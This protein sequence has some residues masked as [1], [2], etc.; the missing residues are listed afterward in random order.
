MPADY[1]PMIFA[2]LFFV[3]V[4]LLYIGVAQ[5]VRASSQRRAI[6]EKIQ[7]SGRQAAFSPVAPPV[8]EGPGFW[9]RSLGLLGK[10]VARGRVEDQTTLRPKF[11]KAGIRSEFAPAVF[12]GAKVVLAVALPL[13]FVGFQLLFPHMLIP[14]PWGIIIFV[15]LALLGFNIPD[16]WL[17]NKI[18]KRREAILNGF[19][20][21]LDLLVVCVQA[22]MGLDAAISRVAKETRYTIPELSDELNLFSL[23]MR[24]GMLRKDAL[25]NL[26][27][28]TDLEQ[29]HN[30]VTLLLQTDKFGTSVTQAL[31]VYSESMRTQ[32]MQRAEARAA[33]MPI[34]LLFPMV[35]F[36]FPAM[37]IAILGSAAIQIYQS[38]ILR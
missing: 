37:F 2:A 1:V 20:D 35:L 13:C 25:K 6:V 4:L 11:L 27:V 24:A 36:I 31:E 23:E 15:A 22:G 19:P 10:K 34:K 18:Q 17:L 12:W 3:V 30:L 5:F 7:T 26:A 14:S 28:R 21:A 38:L 32:R 9:N 29:M 16:L 33:R 8:E